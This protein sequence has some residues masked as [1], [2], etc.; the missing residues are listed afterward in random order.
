MKIID[1]ILN[2]YFS[3]ILI[4]EIFY[5]IRIR[6]DVDTNIEIEQNKEKSLTRIKIMVKPKHY[7]YYTQIY[8]FCK[9]DSFNQL[10]SL[11]CATEDFITKKIKQLDKENGWNKGEQ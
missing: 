3:K 1:N 4:R 7:K 10:T 9:G 2:D 6:N 5:N 11:K 8:D